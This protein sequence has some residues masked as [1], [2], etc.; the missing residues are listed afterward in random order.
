ML[1][2]VEGLDADA[3]AVHEA[4]STEVLDLTQRD[5]GVLA[6]VKGIVDASIIYADYYYLEALLRWNNSK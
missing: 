1:E 3:V 6:I 4:E 2:V 5:I